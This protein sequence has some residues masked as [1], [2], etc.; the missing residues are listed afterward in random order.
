MGGSEE[1]LTYLCLGGS[2]GWKAK[3]SLDAKFEEVAFALETSTTASPKFGE[4][5]TGF[6]YHIIMVSQ[7]S[8]SRGSPSL[9]LIRLKVASSVRFQCHKSQGH[10]RIQYAMSN[11]AQFFLFLSM[12]DGR[13]T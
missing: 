2:L 4:A 6:G 3:G 8:E 11:D 1:K 10:S 12:Q 7:S 13:E 9:T 5:K